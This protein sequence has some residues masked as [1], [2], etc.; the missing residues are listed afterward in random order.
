M[1][2]V[3]F[4]GGEL[5]FHKGYDVTLSF[6]T[7]IAMLNISLIQ[8]ED[9]KKNIQPHNFIHFKFISANASV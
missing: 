8:L 7:P 4:L 9:K 6:G 5:S 3:S 1:L 2:N